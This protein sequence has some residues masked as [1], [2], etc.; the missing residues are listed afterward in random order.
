MNRLLFHCYRGWVGGGYPQSHIYSKCWFYLITLPETNM[1]PESFIPLKNAI[2]QVGEAYFQVQCW[3]SGRVSFHSLSTWTILGNPNAPWICSFLIRLTP[4]ACSGNIAWKKNPAASPPNG[5]LLKVGIFFQ[6]FGLQWHP[7]VF[8]VFLI[9][10]VDG[11]P[12]LGWYPFSGQV[13]L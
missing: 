7:S 9:L 5:K 6:F 3:F 10:F 1:A 4:P 8:D 12:F 13:T 2:S 11:S